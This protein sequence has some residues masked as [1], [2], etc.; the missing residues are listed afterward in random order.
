MI[1]NPPYG[2]SWKK[3]E[4]YVKNDIWSHS[5]FLVSSFQKNE[6]EAV[7]KTNK[8]IPIKP[9]LSATAM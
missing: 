8:N 3:D 7:Y 5:D 1:C 4:K 9:K 6:L 2:D